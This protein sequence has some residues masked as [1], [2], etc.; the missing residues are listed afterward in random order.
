MREEDG[1]YH[2]RI[3]LK[4]IDE[5]QVSSHMIKGMPPM[6]RTLTFPEALRDSNTLA[7]TRSKRPI[8][9]P[10]AVANGKSQVEQRA[11]KTTVHVK[12]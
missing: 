8:E 12:T 1:I 10:T 11:E 6:L 4:L 5:E 9:D 7:T 3:L 2:K